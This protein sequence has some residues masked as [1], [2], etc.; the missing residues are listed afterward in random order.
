MQQPVR[1]ATARRRRWRSLLPVL[2]G[3]M[4]VMDARGRMIFF[5]SGQF[6]KG[7]ILQRARDKVAILAGF[8]VSLAAY[9]A[10][11]LMGLR[12]SHNDFWGNVLVIAVC[13]GGW[14]VSWQL[15]ADGMAHLLPPARGTYSQI[16]SEEAPEDA[17]TKAT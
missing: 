14:L 11:L 9:G 3:Q 15:F 10:A 13:T 8:A 4:L 7:Y 16:L 1:K 17:P 6:G 2:T 5:P 12:L